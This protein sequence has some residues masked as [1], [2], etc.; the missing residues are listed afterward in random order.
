MNNYTRSYNSLMR[1]YF[2]VLVNL[3]NASIIWVINVFSQN[4]GIWLPKELFILPWQMF[5]ELLD[6]ATG[7]KSAIKITKSVNMIENA[8]KGG[9]CMSNV[10][11]HKFSYSEVYV[12]HPSFPIKYLVGHLK[13]SN[14][15]Q[16][17]AMLL[18]IVKSHSVQQN[19]GKMPWTWKLRLQT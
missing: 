19:L 7:S 6:G 1:H 12:I 8:R 2:E 17:K 14:K 18:L 13:R 15:L 9:F 11:L 10:I 4:R 5:N 3:W 16:C